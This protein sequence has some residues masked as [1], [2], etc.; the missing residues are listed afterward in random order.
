MGQQTTLHEHVWYILVGSVWHLQ[1]WGWDFSPNRSRKIWSQSWSA[2][3]QLL[4]NLGRV[5]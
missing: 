2:W 5:L 4:S 3:S 1:S